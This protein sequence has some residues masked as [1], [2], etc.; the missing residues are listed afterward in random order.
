MAKLTNR[1]ECKVWAEK[2]TIS[3]MKGN[4][5]TMC[6]MDGEGISIIKVPI[7]DSMKMVSDMEKE[8]G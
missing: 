5:K 7:G 2:F 1:V 6:I 4:S 8:N 3:Y